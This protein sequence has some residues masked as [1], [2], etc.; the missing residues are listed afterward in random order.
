M[1]MQRITISLPKYLYE[2]LTQQIPSGEISKFVVRAVEAHLLEHESDPFEEFLKLKK[3]FPKI[4]RS[5]IIKAIKKG[6][7]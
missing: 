6:R 3:Q 2:G 7:I 4:K 5:L 1:S